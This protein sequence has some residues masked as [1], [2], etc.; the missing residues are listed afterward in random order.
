MAKN[1]APCR[2]AAVPQEYPIH[3]GTSLPSTPGLS[4]G[5][6]S[7][8]AS[9]VYCSSWSITKEVRAAGPL[10]H[11]YF[12]RLPGLKVSALVNIP[13]AFAKFLLRTESLLNPFGP[14]TKHCTGLTLRDHMTSLHRIT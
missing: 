11:A 8:G 5:C 12:D 10:S 2:V 1:V 4:S 3:N 13:P 9:W 7:G 6:S 14:T